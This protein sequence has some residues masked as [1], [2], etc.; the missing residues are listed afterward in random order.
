MQYEPPEKGVPPENR[1]SSEKYLNFVP[2][3]FT[4]LHK[5]FGPDVHL[6]TR[7]ASPADSHR[8]VNRKLDGTMHNW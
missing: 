3:L 6:L 1:W 5:E 7:R 2:Q 4:W 8:G